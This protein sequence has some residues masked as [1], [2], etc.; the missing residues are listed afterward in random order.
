MTSKLF[1]GQ[2]ESLSVVR[3]HLLAVRFNALSDANRVQFDHFF[4]AWSAFWARLEHATPVVATVVVLV[5]SSVES[6]LLISLHR[7]PDDVLSSLVLIW[8]RVVVFV[9]PLALVRGA[10][11]P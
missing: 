9:R 10:H 6:A 8:E 2:Q 7:T 4:A 11:A 5:H 1:P 3:C